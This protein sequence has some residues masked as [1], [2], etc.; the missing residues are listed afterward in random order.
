G[1]AAGTSGGVAGWVAGAFWACRDTPPPPSGGGAPAPPPATPIALQEAC[2][3]VQGTDVAPLASARWV[4]Q[5]HQVAPALGDE[6]HGDRGQEQPHH[7]LED[8][9]ARLAEYGLQQ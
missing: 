9:A 5:P 8:G 7:P 3:F 1:G 2:C 4:R 6:L